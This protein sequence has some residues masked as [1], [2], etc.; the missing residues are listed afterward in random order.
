MKGYSAADAKLEASIKSG[1]AI[2]A[3]AYGAIQRARQ[4]KGNSV[5]L[6][7]MYFDGLVPKAPDPAADVR[8]A[9]EKRF[10]SV[11]K[12]ADDFRAS[13][14]QRRVGPCWFCIQ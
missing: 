12:W 5:I 9:I 14:K 2:D 8:V 6:H 4:S 10:G 13:A 1:T 11:E 3:D 7:E